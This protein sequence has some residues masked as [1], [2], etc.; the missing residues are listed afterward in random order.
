[1]ANL[2]VV[3]FQVAGHEYVVDVTLVQEIVR[4]AD[5]STGREARLVH[6]DG[7]P[8]YVKGV[9]KLRGRIVPVVDMR[10]HLGVKGCPATAD[11]CA[12]VAK[13]SIGP[14]G[15]IVD[16][17]SELMWV[18][19]HDFQAP[20]PLIA[21]ID[22]NTF[23][24]IC[25]QGMAHLG[26]RLLV[27]L[28]LERML[29]PGE[30]GGSLCGG[31]GLRTRPSPGEHGG[32]LSVEAGLMRPEPVATRPS[33]DEQSGSLS[34]G[35]G[36]RTR[37]SPGEL[38]SG[39]VEVEAQEAGQASARSD[40]RGLVVFEL[41][42][43]SYGV[44]IT[45]VA[46]VREPL[47]IM[48]LPNVP[49]YVLGLINL[50]G[51]I[52]PVLDLRQKFGL[53]LEPDGPGTRLVVLKAL[54]QAQD[55]SLHADRRQNEGSRG[56]PVALRVDRVHGLAR[57]PQVDFQPAPPGVARIDPE[58]YDQV[59]VLDGRLLIELDIQALAHDKPIQKEP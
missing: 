9:I 17:V 34:V 46:Q 2:R 45:D 47:P 28:D 22:R 11:T 1:M 49:S 3:V 30:H 27:M 48:P 41:G 5:L 38:F 24:Q 26:D 29:T 23:P 58:Y 25:L 53:A 33:P 50:R 15:F 32:S 8:E 35:A 37:P 10:K 6:V 44:P 20:L 14:V 51:V 12:I 36:L 39:Q 16:A 42:G 56:C 40:L 18:K 7:A 19:R 4:L 13:L 52:L 55:K 57:L 31:G 54:R 43:E 21:G 59:A